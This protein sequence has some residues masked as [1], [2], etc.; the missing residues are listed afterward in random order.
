MRCRIDS[1]RQTTDYSQTGIRQLICEFFRRLAPVMS[2]V[3][4]ADDSERVM[5]ALLNFAPDIKH[6][7]RGMDLTQRFRVRG[8]TLRDYSRAESLTRFSS[9]GRSTIDSQF[10]IWSATSLPIPSTF[11]T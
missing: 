10:E 2:R 3:A 4:R 1:A 9:A 11:R 6:N 8:R 7:W 5:I